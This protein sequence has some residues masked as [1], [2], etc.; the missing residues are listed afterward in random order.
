MRRGGGVLLF[1]FSLVFSGFL[2]VFFGFSFLFSGFSWDFLGAFKP[3]KTKE[4]QGSGE[5]RGEQQR[6]ATERSTKGSG[7]LASRVRREIFF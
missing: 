7:E 6:S 1:W 3:E 4:N 5:Q 2:G